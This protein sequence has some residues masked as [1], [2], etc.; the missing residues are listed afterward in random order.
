MYE[1][2]MQMNDNRES[3]LRKACCPASV[4]PRAFKGYIL[5]SWGSLILRIPGW[6]VFLE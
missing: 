4:L 6:E 5:R 1:K 2:T 3:V